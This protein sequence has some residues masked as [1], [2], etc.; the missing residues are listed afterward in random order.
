MVCMKF[1]IRIEYAWELQPKASYSEKRLVPNSTLYS[2]FYYN[3]N[4]I[5]APIDSEL[6]LIF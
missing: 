2:F 5:A 1:S 6:D 3:V 4:K